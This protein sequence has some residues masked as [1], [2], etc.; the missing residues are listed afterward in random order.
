MRLIW[1]NL[2]NSGLVVIGTWFLP[3]L[4]CFSNLERC[5]AIRSIGNGQKSCN[6][7]A[8]KSL[9]QSGLFLISEL[10]QENWEYLLNYNEEMSWNEYLAIL[11]GEHTGRNLAEDR[12]RATFLIAE[13]D[14]E[15]IGRALIRHSLNGFYLNFVGHT[16]YGV[17]PKFRRRGFATEI[18]KQSLQYIHELGVTDVLVTCDEHNVGSSKVIVKRGRLDRLVW[19]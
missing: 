11:D 15:L 8:W 3:S 6:R 18:L 12:V 9:E 13:F 5:E 7:Y 16:G 1:H 17:R 19:C 14:G 4:F 10:A 2:L